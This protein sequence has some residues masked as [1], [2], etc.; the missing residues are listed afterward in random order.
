MCE[1]DEGF[2]GVDCSVTQPPEIEEPEEPRE[3]NQQVETC[4]Q[5]P[6]EGD[7]GNTDRS[8]CRLTR[9]VVSVSCTNY[10]TVTLSIKIS[11]TG[12]STEFFY[13]NQFCPFNKRHISQQAALPLINPVVQHQIGMRGLCLLFCKICGLDSLD[14]MV[15]LRSK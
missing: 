2:T 8:I 1:C 15:F 6:I 14:H 10:E 12:M 5:V 3:C 4:D 11:P 13:T 7:F 9:L